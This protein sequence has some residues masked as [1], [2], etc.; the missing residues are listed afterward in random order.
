[1]CIN[2]GVSVGRDQETKRALGIEESGFKGVGCG[3]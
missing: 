1:M 2:V 3:R